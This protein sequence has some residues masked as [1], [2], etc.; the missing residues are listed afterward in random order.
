MNFITIHTIRSQ[1]ADVDDYILLT[2]IELSNGRTLTKVES[3][4]GRFDRREI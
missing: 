3:Q 2:S 1:Q 4:I